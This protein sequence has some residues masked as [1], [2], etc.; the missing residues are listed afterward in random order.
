VRRGRHHGGERPHACVLVA[1]ETP[2]QH[3]AQRRRDPLLGEDLARHV[4]VCVVH[5]AHSLARQRAGQREEFGVV[6][7][8][9]RRRERAHRLERAAR[10]LA[11]AREPPGRARTDV[12]DAHAVDHGFA[13]AV[14]DHLHDLVAGTRQ[15]HAF[16]AEDAD[17]VARV[18]GGD[19]NDAARHG[20]HCAA[21]TGSLFRPS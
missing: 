2:R 1:L 18:H 7:V 15:R 4:L 12:D 13:L 11:H 10:L 19:L 9:Q 3:A 16:L 17:V 5:R 6:H 21:S 14:A 8:H 20:A